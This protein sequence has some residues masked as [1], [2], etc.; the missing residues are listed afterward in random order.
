MKF[1]N[2]KSG[3]AYRTLAKKLVS[4]PPK[5]SKILKYKLN[6]GRYREPVALNKYE[7][8]MRSQGHNIYIQVGRLD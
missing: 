6:Y 8:Y 2:L 3:N 4:S 7:Q 1:E 5:V